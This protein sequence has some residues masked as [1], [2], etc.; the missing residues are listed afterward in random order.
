MGSSGLKWKHAELWDHCSLLL[1]KWLLEVQRRVKLNQNWEKYHTKN[2]ICNG[3]Y[4]AYRYAV[5]KLDQ[6]L[7]KCNVLYDV[8][9]ERK[10]FS[11]I[12]LTYRLLLDMFF[13]Q[14][15]SKTSYRVKIAELFKNY[16]QINNSKN[17]G[18]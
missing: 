6:M 2:A 8:L 15:I 14:R 17:N 18:P 7:S 12:W 13:F 3:D 10:H 4:N 1:Y 5:D 11:F 16:S 9:S